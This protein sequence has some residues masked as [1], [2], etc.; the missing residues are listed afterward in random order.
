MHSSRSFNLCIR[1]ER[2]T[3]LDKLLTAIKKQNDFYKVFFE[4]IGKMQE[5]K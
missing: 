1:G 5:I 2:M 3:E 4:R